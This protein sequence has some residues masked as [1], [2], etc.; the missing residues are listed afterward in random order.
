V[1]DFAGFE[2]WREEDETLVGHPRDPFTRIQTRRSSRHVVVMRDGVVLA[3][4]VRP[5]LLCET[6]LPV[7][8][9]LPRADVR[10]ALLTPSETRTVCAYKGTASYLHAETGAGTVRDLVWTY[11][12]PLHDALAVEEMLC[13]FD[14]RVD[15][16]ID[17]SRVPRPETPWS[18]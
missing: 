18:Q 17:G 4:S 7:R 8:H 3:D 13:F 6:H 11:A 14:E 12:A 15:T 9:Y 5:T 10:T 16:V 2:E 1:L